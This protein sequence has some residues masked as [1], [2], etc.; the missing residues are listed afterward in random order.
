MEKPK[1]LEQLL[2]SIDKKDADTFATFLADDATFK[3]GNADPVNGKAAIH[4]VVA[5]FFLS[6]QAINHEI[7]DTWSYTD[8][9]ICHGTVTYT[10][11][12][13]S[14]L[15]VPFANIFKMGD[16]LIK[17]Y[18]IFVDTSKLYSES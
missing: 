3:F 5:A 1:W 11:H 9:V 15:I 16:N 17:E 10:R 8:A 2:E 14:Q 6:I 13:S 12:D 4:D 7:M 18:L